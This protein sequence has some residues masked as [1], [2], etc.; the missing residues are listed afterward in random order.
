MTVKRNGIGH[1]KRSAPNRDYRRKHIQGAIRKY[2]GINP[3]GD[4]F[5]STAFLRRIWA[6]IQANV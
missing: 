1:I 3:T 4:L 5:P 2:G 6:T